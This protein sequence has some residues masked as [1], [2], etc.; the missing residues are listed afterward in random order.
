MNMKRLLVLETESK[1]REMRIKVVN[2]FLSYNGIINPALITED[3]KM[4]IYAMLVIK[5]EKF[6]KKHLD[7]CFE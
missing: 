6:R 5:A 2:D 7:K 4:S 3:D 1:I